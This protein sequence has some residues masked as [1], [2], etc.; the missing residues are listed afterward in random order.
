M[1]KSRG[2]TLTAGLAHARTIINNLKKM[3][4][5]LNVLETKFKLGGGGDDDQVEVSSRTFE[6]WRSAVKVIDLTAK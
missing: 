3:N 2:E 6:M 1:N 4:T 5:D